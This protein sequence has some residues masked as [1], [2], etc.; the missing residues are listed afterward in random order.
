M[1]TAP[2]VIPQSTLN[3]QMRSQYSPLFLF[4]LSLLLILNAPV[5]GA[6]VTSKQTDSVEQRF[7]QAHLAVKNKNYH[8]AF[9]RLSK[10]ADEGH[11]EAQH[12]V[13]L[14]YEKGIGVKKNLRKAVS[15]YH[16]AADQNVGEAQSALGH[17]YLVGN[18]VLYKDADK[19]KQWLTRAADKE[20]PEAEYSLGLMHADQDVAKAAQYLRSAAQHGVVE[21]EQALAKLPP[22]PYGQAPGAGSVLGAPGDAYGHGLQS[23]K[24]AWS[25]YG[26]LLKSL[27]NVN[28]SFK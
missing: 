10:L 12:F 14:M 28:D 21:A 13:G 9:Q 3:S 1:V 4:A 27:N 11:P 20:V 2:I 18:A 15:Y 22:L 26:D 19:A 17:M 24:H 23:I 25:G 7:E 5:L 8:E 6:E 16:R